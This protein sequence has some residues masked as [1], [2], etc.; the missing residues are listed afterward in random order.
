[1]SK[2]YLMTAEGI[3]MQFLSEKDREDF[4]SST[5]LGDYAGVVPVP[6]ANFPTAEQFDLYM[7]TVEEYDVEQEKIWKAE[8][9]AEKLAKEARRENG[10]NVPVVGTADE[11]ALGSIVENIEETFE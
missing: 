11:H 6:M 10:I 3:V 1:M 4:V 5:G 2:C 8:L 9:E 7:K